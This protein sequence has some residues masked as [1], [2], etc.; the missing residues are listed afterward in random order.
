VDGSVAVEQGI[1]SITARE[2]QHPDSLITE[3]ARYLA[4]WKRRSSGAWRI[5]Y[6]AAVEQQSPRNAK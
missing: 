4:V 3:A 5:N 1:V 2:N 6:F